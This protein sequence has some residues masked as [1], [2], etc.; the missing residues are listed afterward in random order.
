[1]I[2]RELERFED[3]LRSNEDKGANQ[4]EAESGEKLIQEALKVR[5]RN[6]KIKG[7]VKQLIFGYL[8]SSIDSLWTVFMVSKSNGKLEE[9]SNFIPVNSL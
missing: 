5:A 4:H 2:D 6:S 3:T 7:R 8:I 9:I 1:M